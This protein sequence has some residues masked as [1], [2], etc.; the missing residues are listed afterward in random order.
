VPL[1]FST[2]AVGSTNPAKVEAV[3][4][5]LGQLAPA[6]ALEAIE[7]PSGVGAMPLGETAVRAGA[8][9]RARAALERTGADVAFGLEGG[10]I[11]DADDAWLTG[12]VV[13]V[14]RDGRLGE[15]AWGRMLLPRVAAERLRRGEE[16]GDIID[17][18]FARK[19]S[20][21]QGGAIGIL[22]EGA[23]SRT[24]A[25]AYLVAMAC[26]PFLHPE[27]YAERS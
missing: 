9:A 1:R 16:L 17:D 10:A 14:T 25:F 3:R 2:A 8:E 20:K 6:C 22:T 11:L 18:L 27:L 12:H 15:A 24:D 13:A 5:I 21:R 4:R 23:M 19:E 7:V 26:A